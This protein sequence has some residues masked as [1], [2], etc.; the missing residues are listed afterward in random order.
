M[1]LNIDLLFVTFEHL[2][3]KLIGGLLVIAVVW[4]SA[5]LGVDL[6]SASP[7]VATSVDSMSKQMSGKAEQIQGSAKQSIGKAQSAIEDKAASAKMKVKNDLNETKIAVDASNS[8]IEKNTENVAD[9]VKGFF[10]K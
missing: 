10:G 4:Q 8:R 5:F 9:R 1:K 6:A 2:F 3:A 7:L